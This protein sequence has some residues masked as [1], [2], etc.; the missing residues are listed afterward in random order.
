MAIG[1]SSGADVMCGMKFQCWRIVMAIVA[2]L[3]MAVAAGKQRISN[4]VAAAAP[5][6]SWQCV[7]CVAGWRINGR[8]MCMT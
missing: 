4:N 2:I 5:T 1:V 3:S 6:L 8:S 7:M